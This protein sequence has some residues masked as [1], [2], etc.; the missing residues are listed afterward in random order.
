MN[1]QGKSPM[2]MPPIMVAE[3]TPREIFEGLNPTK[4][5]AEGWHENAKNQENGM[6]ALQS[7][8]DCMVEECADTIREME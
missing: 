8:L 7:Q 3:K 1:P 4:E 5:V 2:P 6:A